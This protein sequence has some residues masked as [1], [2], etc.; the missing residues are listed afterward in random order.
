MDLAIAAQS[1][2]A[3]Q[4]LYTD[5]FNHCR[6]AS[7]G[8]IFVVTGENR[9]GQIVIHKGQLIGIAYGGDANMQALKQLALQ[10]SLRHS[11][12]PQLIFPVAET[13][14]PET[15]GQLL[16]AMGFVEHHQPVHK[17]PKEPKQAQP[18]VKQD[19]PVRIYRGQIV[20]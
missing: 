17:T 1:N 11:F 16:K 14:V 12:T 9:S 20:G 7:T 19:K 8:T 3:L 6:Q 2:S 15:A 10:K 5:I 13:L 4:Q 18:A